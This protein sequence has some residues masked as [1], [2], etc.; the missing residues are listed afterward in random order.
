MKQKKVDNFKKI[1]SLL[2]LL[3]WCLL[4]FYF[5]NQ[6][7]DISKNSSNGVIEL[8]NQFL[9]IFSDSVDL[10]GIEG[11]SF[12]IRKSAHIF[13]YFVLYIAIFS[14]FKSFGFL[15][16]IKSY[17]LIL[18]LCLLYAISDEVHQ[19]F[20][21]ERSFGI[22]DILID[23]F[24]SSLGFFFLSFGNKKIKSQDKRMKS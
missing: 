1:F 16:N 7:G 2:F 24:G 6:K 17:F 13:L 23:T 9:R 3:F 8:L 18:G 10:N 12:L 14:V 22:I 19:L 4:I 15:K 21:S 11:I 5:S 20:I